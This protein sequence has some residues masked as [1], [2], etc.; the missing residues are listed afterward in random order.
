MRSRLIAALLLLLYAA[1]LQAAEAQRIR[2][3]KGKTS[4]EVS[5]RFTR[6][7]TERSF[8]LWARKGQHMK[9]E[10][11]PLSPTLITAGTVDSPSGTSD[12]GPGGVIF[13]GDLTETGDY[14]IH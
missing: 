10:I 12:G 9:V 1:D 7:T 6:Q 11:K 2:F 8:V 5:G 13:D 4:V 14:K 3:P